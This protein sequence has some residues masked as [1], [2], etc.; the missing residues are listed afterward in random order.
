M[1]LLSLNISLPKTVSI[2]G[3][4]YKTGIYKTAVSGPRRLARHNLTGDGQGDMKNHGGEYQAVYCY[5]HEHYAYWANQ[6]A[7]ADFEFGQFGENFTLEGLLEREVCV[8][9]VFQVGG[10]LVQVTQPRVPCYK[11]ADKLGIPGFDKTFLRANRSGFYLRVLEAG[12][13]EAGAPIELV[14][15]GPIGM[16]VAEVNAALYLDKSAAA[17]ERALRIDALSPGWKR[18]FEKLLAKG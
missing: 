5:P 12:L 4:T 13:V 6:L 8:G 1:K 14:S 7:R 16:T 18:S 15:N 9:D 3:R 11:L 17:A 10:A 2:N